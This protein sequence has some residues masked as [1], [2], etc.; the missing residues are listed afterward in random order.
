MS[1]TIEKSRPVSVSDHATP[2]RRARGVL[3]DSEVDG[4]SMS[5]RRIDAWLGGSSRPAS[6]RAVRW[7]S[8]TA[9]SSWAMRGSYR[10]TVG[11]S[12]GQARPGQ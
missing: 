10:P 3:V 8:T 5:R 12:C 9:V 6:P 2:H 1:N 4:R 7:E 11:R